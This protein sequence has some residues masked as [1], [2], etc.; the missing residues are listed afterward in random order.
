MAA[1]EDLKE[2]QRALTVTQGAS[3]TPR[4][5][6]LRF[7]TRHQP[8][9]APYLCCKQCTLRLF[10]CRLKAKA[11]VHQ[12]DVVV[13][14]L[15]HANHSAH[16]ALRFTLFGDGVRSCVAAITAHH[17][18]LA[19]G[20]G[21]Q[22]LLLLLFEVKVTHVGPQGGRQ[23]WKRRTEKGAVRTHSTHAYTSTKWEGQKTEEFVALR[24]LNTR[25][26]S[27]SKPPILAHHAD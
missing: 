9:L 19:K 5:K 7:K 2:C 1:L 22:A 13:D 21:G 16:D 27:Q 12:Q 24:Q 17:K 10:H 20:R 15:G 14:R 18:N 11:P 4:L 3:S 8:P 26:V 25:W 23:V 6:H